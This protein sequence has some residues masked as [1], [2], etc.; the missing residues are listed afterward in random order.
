M[1]L[2]SATHNAEGPRAAQP[3]AD[4]A[5]LVAERAGSP[6][7]RTWAHFAQ[8]VTRYE[9]GDLDGAR[10]H[11]RRALELYDEANAIAVPIDPRVAILGYAALAEVRSGYGDRG[12]M[13]ARQGV[14][15]A[16][17]SKRPPDRAWAEYHAA[18]TFAFLRDPGN[19]TAHAAQ[20]REACTEEANPVLEAVAM[21][22][23][24][25]AM[26]ESGNTTEGLAALR[27]GLARFA[28]TGQRVGLEAYLGL[29]ADGLAHA[30][31]FAEALAVLAEAEGA[32]TGDEM[33]RPDTLRRRAELL[34]RTGAPDAEVEATF[35]GSV[36]V[37]RRQGA[38]QAELWTATSYAR[39]LRDHGRAA[40]G[41]DLL[42]PLYAWFTEG[43]DTRD[44]IEAKALL[45]ELR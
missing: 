4:Q 18:W 26:M 34:A 16:R 22:L 7:M 45:D 43:F 2:W 5:L 15:Q 13:L 21:V 8:V 19:V 41:H 1:G 17:R 3:L 25:L 24:G 36:E 9:L 23:G 40:E 32:C 11:A 42:A 39:W 38:K 29:L 35:A 33:Y 6:P 44:L 37:A 30:G 28:A 31:R 10:E 14:E 27:T 12:R 20:V